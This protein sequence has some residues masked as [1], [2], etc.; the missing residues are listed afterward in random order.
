MLLCGSEVGTVITI[1]RAFVIFRVPGQLYEATLYR[2][3]SKL[4]LY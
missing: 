4:Y 2:E 3:Q 1:L